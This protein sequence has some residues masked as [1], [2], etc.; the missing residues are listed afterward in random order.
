MA[1]RK[2]FTPA[3]RKKFLE[4]LRE[5]AN[6]T[7]AA[8]SIGITRQHMYDLKREDER[9]AE[10]WD[11]AVAEG[12]DILEAE[13]WRRG[14]QGYQEPVFYQGE[15]CGT[16]IKYSDRLLERL[17][18]AHKPDKFSRRQINTNQGPDGG[19]MQMQHELID[20]PVKRFFE[21]LEQEQDDD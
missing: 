9:L 16:V 20:N 13:A 8:S 18:E 14:Y 5:T 4:K 21:D 2:K 10:E 15:I 17:L 11:N 1:N 12:A 3:K 7:L 19:P 6:V